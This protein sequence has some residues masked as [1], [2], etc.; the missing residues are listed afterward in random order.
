MELLAQ[1]ADILLHLDN[2]LAGFVADYG[3]WIYVLLFAIVFAETGL[4]VTPFLPGDSLLFVAGTLAATG[5]MDV[6]W[7]GA[8]LLT[9]A[10]L[11]DTVN[12]W[13]GK[14][15][16]LRLFHDPQARFFKREYLDRTHRFYE[17]HGGKTIIIARFVPIVRTFAPFV[18]GVGRMSYPRFFAYNIIGAI[19]WVVSLV[20]AGY[21]FGNLPVVKDNLTLVILTIVFLSVLPGIIEYWRHRRTI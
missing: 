13:I 12:Y 5:G 6:V 15:F 10:I 16:G 11:G 17:R 20:S 21:Y 7:L 3:A 18:A 9:A 8:V 4:V 2:Y 14:W 19:L 1:F